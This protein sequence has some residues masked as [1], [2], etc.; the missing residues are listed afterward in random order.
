MLISLTVSAYRLSGLRTTDLR[1]FLAQMVDDLSREP[2]PHAARPSAL[3]FRAFVEAAGGRVRGQ[4][5]KDGDGGGGGGGGKPHSASLVEEEAAADGRPVLPPLLSLDLADEEQFGVLFELLRHRPEVA[6][7]Y[8]NEHV[9]PATLEFQKQRLS[10]SGQ[11][12]G[13]ELLF[14]RRL[15]F[16]G[17]PSDLLPLE[18]KPCR[19]EPGD[20]T[21]MA[22]VLMDP[23]V[24]SLALLDAGW[25]VN[26]ALDWVATG[27]YHALIDCGALVT[28][29][30]N[31]GVARR[32]L[33][34]GLV[35]LKGCVFL[36]ERDEKMV[37]SHEHRAQER[38]PLLTL[39]HRFLVQ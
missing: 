18:S 10:A 14:K 11:E 5:N 13:G 39:F 25:S 20:E 31:A 23:A 4:K 7:A 17:T 33:E 12:V 15:G 27:G 16:S 36:N 38:L 22:K 2:G 26:S 3:R 24:M 29:F 28:G 32:L 21:K 35:G 34:R 30:S 8:L 6:E 1:A 37:R 9:F 19:Y